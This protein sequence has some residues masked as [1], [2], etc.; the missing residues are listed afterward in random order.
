MN[1]PAR[2]LSPAPGLTALD[3]AMVEILAEAIPED[4]DIGDERA[5][6]RTLAGRA[7][8][9]TIM[10]LLDDVI[11]HARTLRRQEFA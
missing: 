5:V 7:A 2:R 9:D 6:L 8:P 11:E 10:T 4:C 1:A 3:E